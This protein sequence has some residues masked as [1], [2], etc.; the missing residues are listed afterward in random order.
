MNPFT[1]GGSDST[2]GAVDAVLSELCEAKRTGLLAT[3]Y[4]AFETRFLA[5]EGQELHLWA[6]M[7]KTTAEH[8]LSQQAVRIRFPWNL[9]MWAGPVRILGYEQE[10]KR[11]FLRVSIPESLGPDEQRQHWR[12]DRCGKSTGTLANDELTVVR[13]TLE[14]LSQGGAGIFSAEAMDPAA[15]GPGR[16]A[17]LNL[18]LEG[19]LKVQAKVRVVQGDAFR[20]GLVFD[21][22]LPEELLGRLSAWIRPRF[23]EA[24]RNWQNRAET[25]AQAVQAA[26]MAVPEGILLIASDPEV[27]AQVRPVLEG[28][29][30]LRV[31]PP[32]MSGLKKALQPAPLVALLY[33][34]Q[35]GLEERRRYRALLE[36]LPN[37]P[38]ILLSTPAGVPLAQ[39]L[40]T[41]FKALSLAWNPSLGAFLKRMV[42]GLLKRQGEGA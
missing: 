9:T 3:P 30:D 33:L 20:L 34:P 16:G 11:R 35:S 37:C 4:L 13:I 25:R 39:E 32:V 41:E 42:T 12:A 26:A 40:G 18:L 31:A 19:G 7:S 22:P 6:T 23:E 27:E 15:F 10:A 21:P 29:P 5:R 36:T 17:T 2:T 28:L 14:N 8:T 38:T 1:P 24:K